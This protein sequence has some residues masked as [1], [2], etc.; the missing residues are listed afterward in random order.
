MTLFVNTWRETVKDYK[1]QIVTFLK[2]VFSINKETSLRMGM[3]DVLTEIV[4]DDS[5]I[6]SDDD[7]RV[8]QAI[9]KLSYE[10]FE[11]VDQLSVA[12]FRT[13]IEDW[14]FNR[15]DEMIKRMTEF[16]SSVKSAK[17]VDVSSTTIHDIINVSS[18][19][20]T[21]PMGELMKNSLETV[22][23]EFGESVSPEEK[24]SILAA[25]MNKLM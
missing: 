6:L 5:V 4:G 17:K 14:N 11:A 15:I 18:D 20:E 25:M 9:T 3:N 22:F 13:H 2:S 8:Y 16:L 1:D 23:E 10:N 21:T 12:I 7:M 19:I 24:I